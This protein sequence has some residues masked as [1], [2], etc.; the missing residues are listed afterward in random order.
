MAVAFAAVVRAGVLSGASADRASAWPVSAVVIA[1]IAALWLAGIVRLAALFLP[2]GREAASP[3]HSG[4]P[5][6]LAAFA[7]GPF[8]VALFF[9]GTQFVR[10][11]AS[12]FVAYPLAAIIVLLL[13]FAR[14]NVRLLAERLLISFFLWVA[15][16]IAPTF[17]RDPV[18]DQMSSFL[19]GLLEAAGLQS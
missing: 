11:P 18:N 17:W 19:F 12:G 14:A 15:I 1:V 16:L 3:P 10:F 9:F 13:L 2:R 4:W 7:A 5:A 8:L 6:S